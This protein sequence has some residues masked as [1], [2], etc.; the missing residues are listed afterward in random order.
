[1]K[2]CTQNS[3]YSDF[4]SE[5]LKKKALKFELHKILEFEKNS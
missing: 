3:Y 1:M 5:D 4:R 2:S